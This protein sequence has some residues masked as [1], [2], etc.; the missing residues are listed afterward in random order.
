MT[1]GRDVYSEFLKSLIDAEISRK[2]SLEQRGLAVI[3]TSGALVTLLFGSMAVYTNSKS[4]KQPPGEKG[5]FLIAA[6]CFVLAGVTAIVVNLPL[7]YGEIELTEEN[8]RPVWG[9]TASDAQ[10]AVAAIRL[11]RLYSAKKA[12]TLKAYSLIIA[13]AF[14]LCAAGALA[15]AVNFIIL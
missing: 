8:L 3:T 5:L 13:M 12:N 15:A 1:E 9:D 6:I 2:A 14:E 10:A 7:F 11:Q 4:F